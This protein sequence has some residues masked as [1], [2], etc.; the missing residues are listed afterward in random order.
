MTRGR[1]KAERQ[2]IFHVEQDNPGWMPATWVVRVAVRTRKEGAE[3]AKK[4][5]QFLAVQRAS[6]PREGKKR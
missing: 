5:N 3:L 2:D 6:Q 1:T 4:I